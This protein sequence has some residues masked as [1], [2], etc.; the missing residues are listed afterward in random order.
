MKYEYTK[1]NIINEVLSVIGENVDVGDEGYLEPNNSE[2]THFEKYPVKYLMSIMGNFNEF[3]SWFENEIES[4]SDIRGEDYFEDMLDNEIRDPVIIS[5]VDNKYAVW[6]GWHRIAAAIVSRKKY[7]P[8]ILGTE[9][10]FAP[11]YPKKD[12]EFVISF[13]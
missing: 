11:K 7:I 9:N 1:E 5:Y 3:K 12:S 10:E 2:W 8:V 6:D 13:D 4:L